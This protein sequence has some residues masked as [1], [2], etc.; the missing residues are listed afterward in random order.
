M[1]K[2]QTNDLSN[3]PPWLLESLRESTITIDRHESKNKNKNRNNK[4]IIMTTSNLTK[5][6]ENEKEK[7][8]KM[9]IKNNQKQTNFG[10]TNEILMMIEKEKEFEKQKK[11]SQGK[12]NLKKESPGSR[13][14]RRS[15]SVGHQPR[16]CQKE[17]TDQKLT[18]LKKG[19]TGIFRLDEPVDQME[20]LGYYQT[21]V[22]LCTAQPISLSSEIYST[23][24]ELLKSFIRQLKKSLKKS[25]NFLPDFATSSNKFQISLGCCE[26]LL[27]Y[28]SKCYI[29]QITYGEHG[30]P[31][32]SN[33]RGGMKRM[34]LVHSHSIKITGKNNNF[35]NN[36]L[37]EKKNK[38][39]QINND[40]FVK[41][42]HQKL[43]IVL[44]PDIELETT[45]KPKKD[46]VRK[47]ENMSQ[48]G[49]GT[50][51]GLRNENEEFKRLKNEQEKIG[52]FFEP[53]I[54]FDSDSD[55]E[56]K[57]E[58][59]PKI[60]TIKIKNKN[61][62]TNPNTNTNT[63][64]NT[65][66]K[67]NPNN[68]NGL[69]Q[70]TKLKLKK[71]N[72][73]IENNQATI[74]NKKKTR[75]KIYKRQEI[76]PQNRN[77][78]QTI[79]NLKGSIAK[80]QS[81]PDSNPKKKI[82]KPKFTVKSQLNRKKQ[83]KRK[84]IGFSQFRKTQINPYRSVTR[85][86]SAGG[87]ST[88]MM[89]VKAL[90]RFIWYKKIYLKFKDKLLNE[91]LMMIKDH[92]GN[93]WVSNTDVLASAIRSLV[94]TGYNESEPLHIYH[95]FEKLLL[96]STSEYYTIWSVNQLFKENG[97]NHTKYV[98]D[99]YKIF[100]SEKKRAKSFF[101]KSTYKKYL[102]VIQLQTIS[103][104][105]DVLI[106]SFLNKLSNIVDI[107]NVK[108]MKDLSFFHFIIKKTDKGQIELERIF[109]K[110]LNSEFEKSLKYLSK[111]EQNTSNDKTNCITTLV[112][113][114][115]L[116][117]KIIEKGFNEDEK[118]K[119]LFY[120]VFSDVLI[121]N[122]KTP[123][124]F[125]LYYHKI[126][127]G[128]NFNSSSDEIQKMV[129]LSLELI[130]FLKELDI[131]QK[132]Y[133]FYLS[134]RLI[135]NYSE[136]NQEN[137]LL[138]KLRKLLGFDFTRR[139]EKLIK[140]LE[141]SKQIN[142]SY[143][144]FLIKER[145]RVKQNNTKSNIISSFLILTRS[146]WDINFNFET[147]LNNFPLIKS[148][149][150]KFQGFYIK[151]NI[152]QEKKVDKIQKKENEE[153]ENQ[154]ENTSENENENDKTEMEIEIEKG[155]FIENDENQMKIIKNKSETE[156]KIE[157]GILIEN[158]KN[159]MKIIKE[160]VK[161]SIKEN[162]LELR[163][164][165]CEKVGKLLNIVHSLSIVQLEIKY[166]K[167]RYSLITNDYQAHILLCFNQS[168][169]FNNDELKNYSQIEDSF[170]SK[171]VIS[172]IRNKI[173]ISKPKIQLK[174]LKTISS[175]CQ[176]QINKRYSNKKRIIRLKAVKI[177]NGFDD[178]D[179]IIHKQIHLERK[180]LIQSIIIR[181][182]KHRKKFEHNLLINEIIEQTKS[183]FSP[184]LEIILNCIKFLIKNNY[185][186]KIEGSETE[187]VYN[188]EESLK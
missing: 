185:L 110:Y 42:E 145:G 91:I 16:T 143:Q 21:V 109:Q 67:L 81:I 12:E 78:L 68:N 24:N 122:T 114:Y 38:K 128:K 162:Q 179:K 96:T 134:Q 27:K 138:K 84:K 80:S 83:V 115:E 86:A 57:S 111:E 124:L 22:D 146:N 51:I 74:V 140:D 120:K 10:T 58:S 89:S 6:E 113:L 94:N 153:N 144:K 8:Q 148:S 147:K 160:D 85:G 116:F 158:D 20:W 171:I 60:R 125:A 48:K 139:M 64:I 65:K 131:F 136:I 47:K 82:K 2:D 151:K 142:N 157:K 40:Y 104:H 101:H 121:K 100:E 95:E 159:Q 23:F 5:K 129:N 73:A 102:E 55:S 186:V 117:S 172:L 167:K 126:L 77:N 71:N 61:I 181:I 36:Q 168:H 53:D 3:T 88:P 54:E 63:N 132:Y 76:I 154:N 119:Q 118:M 31:R 33:P 123:Q 177:S 7:E 170:Y 163:G 156:M 169:S 173:L 18:H 14:L 141:I 150:N 98:K 149:F 105:L 174:N 90:G 66:V 13:R 187:Y 137:E 1:N 29:S 70:N 112:N 180:V 130:H 92:R 9:E 165:L 79:L 11:Y 25:S 106:G 39:S 99:L 45:L 44:E 183:K 41:E 19:L 152:D 133:L 35:Y 28:L 182:L 59:K 32:S 26:D 107:E 184:K 93:K 108:L 43:G 72:Q 178:E 135:F 4:N 34:G 155:I 30:N 69:I 37:S 15:V 52:I 75:L 62:T 103:N 164:G 87:R 188:T 166:L 56:F 175:N 97:K 50:K 17:R 46:Q 49:R 176:I 127:K 161:A